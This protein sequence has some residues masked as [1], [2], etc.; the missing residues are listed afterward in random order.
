MAAIK[1]FADVNGQAVELT[2]VWGL[3]NA[4]FAKA[5]PGVKGRRYDGFKRMVGTPAGV[6][7]LDVNALPVTRSIEFK[8]N[9]SKRLCDARCLNA[10]GRIMKCECSCGGKNHGAGSFNCEAA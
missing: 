8:S 9:P 3:D 6:P 7:A 4:D 10:T 1:H 5:F 2:G